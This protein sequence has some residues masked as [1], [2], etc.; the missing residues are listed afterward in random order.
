MAK[1]LR[2]QLVEA[3]LATASQAKKAEKQ[4]RT[5]G[6]AHRK[7]SADAVT[8]AGGNKK[9]GDRP[10]A[11]AKPLSEAAKKARQA[12]SDKAKRDRE[13]AQERNSKAAAKAVR[14]Q[15]KQLV[16]QNDVREK[17]S[18]E[19][20][21]PYNFL[22]G[23]KIKRIHV[24]PK[25]QEMLSKGQLA[26]INNDGRY[27]LVSKEIAAKIA[28]RDPKWVI[29]AHDPAAAKPAEEMDDFYKDFQVP[30]DLDW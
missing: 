4:K 12:Q 20:D 3:G 1:S 16:T 18:R 2:D 29:A 11:K 26:I 22:H 10:S 14:A 27:H 7:K 21:V 19:D 5:E 28:E 8:K 6:Q 23:K 9:K 24:P 25:Q 13:L 15:I 30:D 17:G